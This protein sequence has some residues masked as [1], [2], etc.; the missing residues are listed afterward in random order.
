MHHM[1]KVVDTDLAYLAGLIDGEGYVGIKKG[2]RHD[3][4]SPA[5]H[6]RIQVRMVDEPAIA[7]LASTLG[8]NYYFEKA[9]SH[10]GR[11]LFCCYSASDLKACQVLDAVLPWLRVKHEN[12]LTV[13]RLRS[14]KGAKRTKVVGEKNFPNRVGTVRMVPVMA[15]S[16]ENLA[17]REALY[18]RCKELN[19]TGI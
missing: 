5:Y 6:E 15:L 10:L 19:R 1:D 13:L 2:T 8:G 4:T 11:P 12:A 17:A 14:L 3:M 9:H 7:F 16:D 18:L